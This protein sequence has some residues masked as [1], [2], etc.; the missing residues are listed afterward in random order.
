MSVAIGSMHA[1]SVIPV[2]F[3]IQDSPTTRNNGGSA[4]PIEWWFMQL[5][6]VPGPTECSEEL[7]RS[8][9]L[10]SP[11]DDANS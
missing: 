1:S 3:T 9:G 11:C 6:R 8:S 5:V 7:S 2:G 4:D 10:S